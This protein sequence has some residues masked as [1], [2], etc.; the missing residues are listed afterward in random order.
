[1]EARLTTFS[2]VESNILAADQAQA[3][4]PVQTAPTASEAQPAVTEQAPEAIAN[5]QTQIQPETQAPETVV[6]NDG[7]SSDF[8]LD[9]P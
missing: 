6:D 4:S 3:S 9:I 8:N 7:S 1:M 2:Q 5:E